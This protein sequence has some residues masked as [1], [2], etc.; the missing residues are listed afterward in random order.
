MKINVLYCESIYDDLIENLGFN[1]ES[2][3]SFVSGIKEKCKSSIKATYNKSID[4]FIITEE[5]LKEWKLTKYKSYE[6]SEF[7]E[8]NYSCDDYAIID[9]LENIDVSEVCD[10]IFQEILNNNTDIIGFIILN[11]F[12][13]DV[14]ETQFKD[15]LNFSVNKIIQNKITDIQ[16]KINNNMLD[17]NWTF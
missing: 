7:I 8:I 12:T 16:Y 1:E 15:L 10:Y 4:A 3:V 9:G 11:Y 17:I 13:K 14:I 5:E 2:A 6:L